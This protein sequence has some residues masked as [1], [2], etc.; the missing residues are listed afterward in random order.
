[1]GTC[2]EKSPKTLDIKTTASSLRRKEFA[3]YHCW[4]KESRLHLTL[5]INQAIEEVGRFEGI[6]C[7]QEAIA[8]YQWSFHS[9]GSRDGKDNCYQW[10]D[11][12]HAQLPPVGFAETGLPILL[13]A[14][15]GS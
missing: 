12:R 15:T 13:A 3:V 2:I 8:S 7:I 6:L 11:R 1:M 9:R 5:K 10:D 4:K 14:G